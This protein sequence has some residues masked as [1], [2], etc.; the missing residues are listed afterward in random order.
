[1]VGFS[2]TDG[3]KAE[4]LKIYHAIEA[5]YRDGLLNGDERQ[6]LLLSMTDCG[7]G[8]RNGHRKNK[9]KENAR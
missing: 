4:L 6:R 2:L 1:M 5:A 3:Q 8:S 9:M 7:M